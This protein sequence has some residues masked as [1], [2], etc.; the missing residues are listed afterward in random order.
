MRRKIGD[1]DRPRSSGKL[2]W[3]TLL[4]VAGIGASC[5][6]FAAVTQRHNRP[7][8]P[9]S[10]S[11]TINFTLTA[12]TN[13]SAGIFGSDGHLVRTLWG[14]QAYTAGTYQQSWD[15][16]D[17][18]GN[19]V[20]VDTFTA[21][22][23][24]HNVYPNWDGT[25]GNSSTYA[26]GTTTLTG[27][28]G[29]IDVLAVG[30]T[31]YLLRN[32]NERGEKIDKFDRGT[33]GQFSVSGQTGPNNTT[34]LPSYYFPTAFTTDGTR[35]YVCASPLAEYT[36]NP[37]P[38]VCAYNLDETSG[39]WVFTGITPIPGGGVGQNASGQWLVMPAGT[40]GPN[41][42]AVQKNGNLLA[43][44]QV[45][46][47]QVDFVDKLTGL[48]IPGPQGVL[49]FPSVL[50]VRWS[51][52]D[53]TLWT[54]SGANVTGWQ[55][56][57]NAWTVVATLHGTSEVKTFAV[58]P[59]DGS[60]AILYGGSDQQVRAYTPGGTWL[61]SIGARGGYAKGP[62]VNDTKFMVAPLN[63][64]INGGLSFQNDGKLWV[65]D[66]GNMRILR[67]PVHRHLADAR[68]DAMVCMLN[69]YMLAV[70]PNNPN[71]MVAEG[72]LEF[73]RDYTEPLY[74]GAGIAWTLTKNWG[75]G[76]MG[77]GGTNQSKDGI[78]DTVT[79]SNGRIYA[80]FWPSLY[81]YPHIA[82][83]TSNGVRDIEQMP[84]EFEHIDKNMN[85]SYWHIDPN[86]NV[87]TPMFGAFTGFDAS[88]NPVWA[89]FVPYCTMSSATGEPTY[90]GGFAVQGG[91]PLE[92]LPDGSLPSFNT[93]VGP[94]DYNSYYLGFIKPGATDFW[95]KTA[96]GGYAVPL[97]HDG[98]MPLLLP[99]YNIIPD[100]GGRT[101]GDLV[102]IFAN[103]EFFDSAEANQILLYHSSGLFVT[104]FGTRASQTF[105]QSAPS[106]RSGNFVA[107][108][109]VQC[110]DG[111][112][113]ILHSDESSHAGIH[114]WTLENLNS[115]KVASAT[116]DQ[117]GNANFGTLSLAVKPEAAKPT[118][119]APPTTDD[120]NRADSPVV[121]NGWQDVNSLFGIQGGRLKETNAGVYQGFLYSEILR[122]DL[123]PDSDQTL[124]IPAQ[125]FDMTKMWSFPGVQVAGYWGLLSRFQSDGSR[126]IGAL[127]YIKS[128]SDV[129][130]ISG[131]GTFDI[132]I[133]MIL[134]G[135]MY[136]L[137]Y[138][139]GLYLP[140]N[141][142]HAYSMEFT[143][144]GIFPTYLHLKV[145]DT[146]TGQVYAQLDQVSDQPEFQTTGKVGIQGGYGSNE[147]SG[148][149]VK[150]SSSS[151]RH[152]LLSKKP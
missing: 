91:M 10:G 115:I 18:F 65:M 24:T 127:Q 84:S 111:N 89:P 87:T 80:M 100:V 126:Y 107:S 12:P 141:P 135:Q 124:Q 81:P 123:A 2:R 23:L 50:T 145:W 4:A 70:D 68:K 93:T 40:G 138:D 131:N 43:I 109:F 92:P 74:R 26:T 88:N 97:T 78:I 52:D 42:V 59:T 57:N 35:M 6:G 14:N 31:V 28:G 136:F 129:S 27:I 48:P 5:V 83:L 144:S 21:K 98:H 58:N 118:T 39:A 96:K 55:F 121:G 147:F 125:C 63:K 142:G 86:N 38:I 77:W 85:R 46:L 16:T 106:G 110:S 146:T 140:A 119:S 54:S 148:Y 94:A 32:F 11:Y 8:H 7:H 69:G 114:E 133:A 90:T 25:I 51:P 17:D 152:Q 29:C 45:G 143:T 99:A 22:V 95:A 1:L 73:Q 72:Y 150:F 116:F 67:F 34:G 15:G 134:N 104:D 75:Q 56:V 151:L 49:T 105:L 66:D 41:S 137:G 60:I 76:W 13:M 113:R 33:P 47:N 112:V 71:R 9:L 20:P 108:G 37:N 53:Q 36:T 130:A 122:P 62:A 30:Q 120:F 82:E 139:H 101:C 79:A 102:A 103:G 44:S 128:P 64:W 132:F 61:Y 19:P 149:S 3:F 117:T